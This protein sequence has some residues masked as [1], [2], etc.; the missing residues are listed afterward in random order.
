L[1]YAL[2]A[3]KHY[4]EA[5]DLLLDVYKQDTKRMSPKRAAAL[6]LCYKELGDEA[7]KQHWADYAKAHDNLKYDMNDIPRFFP[8][9]ADDLR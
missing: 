3:L 4:E 2:V 9:I 8:S 6:A 7:R 5:K 1:A